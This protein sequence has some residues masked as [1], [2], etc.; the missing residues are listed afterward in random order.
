MKAEG[1]GKKYVNHYRHSFCMACGRANPAGLHL[2]FLRQ[3]DGSVAASVFCAK[4]LSGYD[5]LLH[6]GAAALMLDSAMTNCLFSAGIAAL[7]GKLS[8]RYRTP[9]KTGRAAGLKAWI[10]FE[11]PPLYVLKSELRQDGK[12]KVSAEARFIKR[13]AAVNSVQ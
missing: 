9:V 12:L 2:K 13:D 6:G 3:P 5:G 7:T 4:E 10:E 1:D 11:H 8:V